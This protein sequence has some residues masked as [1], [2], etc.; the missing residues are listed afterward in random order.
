MST[1]Y[2]ILAARDRVRNHQCNSSCGY[3]CPTLR[4]LSAEHLTI[5]GKWG[6]EP[7]DDERQREQYRAMHG[8]S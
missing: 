7:G 2:D 5:A 1:R 6:I 3:P 4:A 8:D